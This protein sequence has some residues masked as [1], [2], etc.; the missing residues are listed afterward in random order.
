MNKICVRHV[1][2][3]DILSKYLYMFLINY[4]DTGTP[5]L[6]RVNVA[7]GIP[8]HAYTQLPGLVVTV[9]PA[10]HTY[11]SIGGRVHNRHCYCY[12]CYTHI[13]VVGA[14][15]TS[16]LLV[17]YH[18]YYVFVIDLISTVLKRFLFSIIYIASVLKNI[19]LLLPKIIATV[20]EMVFNGYYINRNYI[21]V[22]EFLKYTF[23][24][25]FEIFPLE[26]LL[27]IYIYY[28]MK[29]VLEKHLWILANIFFK[30]KREIF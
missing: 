10:R 11:L 17:P 9:C 7:F 30:K 2:Y 19:M 27:K 12:W 25:Y 29:S 18:R 6:R 13:T 5:V 24:K 14:K 22:L 15:C 23:I 3:L 8:L 26:I 4:L 16:L 1:A 28:D 21:I 20:F